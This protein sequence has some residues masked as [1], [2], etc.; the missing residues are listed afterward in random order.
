MQLSFAFPWAFLA[1][2]LILFLPRYGNWV[3]RMLALTLLITALAQPRLNRPSQDIAVL[4]DVSDSIGRQALDALSTF[5]FSSLQRPPKIYYFASDVT[6]GTGSAEIPA[7]LPTERSDFARA[8]QVAASAEAKRILLLS[9]GAQSAG[10]ALLALPNIPVDTY[11]VTGLANARLLSLL[12]PEQASPGE[13]VEVIAVIE[14]DQEAEITLRPSVGDEALAAVRQRV[15]A[16]RSPIRFSFPVKGETDLTVSASLSVDFEQ[17][18]AD[19][20]QRINIAVS[21]QDPILVIG[22]PALADLLTTQGFEVNR[23][24]PA[25]IKSPLPYSAIVLRESAKLFTPG[26]LEL[27]Q[28][29]VRNGGGLLMSGGPESFGLGAWYRTAVEEVLPVNTDLR[30]DVELP[31]VAM[32][33]VL[34]RSQSMSSGNPSK[35]ALAKEG[36]ISVVEL[37]YQEDRLGLIVFGDKTDWIFKLRKAT[38]RGK[39]EMLQGILD[40]STQGGTILEP[41]YREAIAAL[42][43]SEAAI[44]HIIIL[45][46]GQLYDGRGPFSGGSDVNFSLI[47]ALGL[48]DGITTSTIA[49]GEGAD[50]QRLEAIALSGGG[51]Y[52]RTLDVST[53]PQIF[54]SE[55]LTATRSLLREESLQPKPRPHP[56][57]TGL[58][59]SLPTLDAYIASSLKPDGEMLLEGIEGEP[60]L[61][62]SRQ[63]LG[64][65]AAFTTDLNSWAGAFGRWPQ[66]PALLGTVMRWLQTSPANYSATITPL[67]NKLKVVVDAVK[68][69]QYINN[70]SLEARYNGT[71]QSLTQVAPGRYEALL[72]DAS[73][74]GGTLIVV[75]G[76]EIVARALVSTPNTEFDKRGAGEFLQE[77]A[78]QTGGQ[79]LSE[80]G[81]YAPLTPSAATALWQWPAAAG[82]LIFMLEL[83]I[84]RFLPLRFRRQA[85]AAD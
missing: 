20:S 15:L 19:D 37:A 23:G 35:V 59:N 17:P 69:G 33:I 44:K 24:S 21:E 28:S 56:L 54:T 40:I 62:I 10:D 36:A 74:E 85:T 32:V 60:V 48:R 46:D 18:Q 8:L 14:S 47:A 65:S 80:A 3:W 83:L 75:S 77:I 73:S 13:T 67:G 49:I 64:R 39:R 53:L 25:N 78:R 70:Q 12:A 5:D 31:L 42:N 61:A 82:L 29:Y 26:Q 72:D 11:E 79:V 1:L 66:L 41:A 27:L 9:D 71:R 63:G 43:Q 45:S 38:E 84:R 16:G 7:F 68:D 55:A 4:V 2:A 30:S 50:F 57:N 51:R 52:Y 34:D 22:D 6:A 76:S 81:S 58:G